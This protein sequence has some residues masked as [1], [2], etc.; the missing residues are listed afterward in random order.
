MYSAYKFRLYPN[1][2]QTRELE[3]M[4]ETHRRLYND[5][6]DWRKT[7]W[8]IFGVSVSGRSQERWYTKA[9]RRHPFYSR[10]NNN[11]A[12]LTIKRLDRAFVMFFRGAQDGVKWGY[13]RFKSKERFN[14]F[15]FRIDPRGQANGAKLVGG[16]LR[17]QHVG[18]IPVKLHRDV[19]G[20]PR[21]LTL[22]CEAGK[23][24]VV[25]QCDLGD[26]SVAPSSRPAVGIDLGIESFL[27]TSE[28][29]QEPNPRFFKSAMP[30]LRK[31]ARA[32]SRKLRGGKNRR[33]AAKRLARLH[34][35]VR[36]LRREHHHQIS[37]K[38]VRRHGLIAAERLN[39][40][41]MVRNSRRAG[42]I[43]DA[44]WFGFL[45]ILGHKAESAGVRV[46]LVEPR[47]TSQECSRCGKVV[48]KLLKVRWHD[49]PHCGLSLHRDHNAALN[50]LARARV[51]AR[52]WACGTERSGLPQACPEKECRKVDASG[53]GGPSSPFT[54][55]VALPGR[56]AQRK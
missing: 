41:G 19:Q 34:S 45:T 43:K 9:W 21:G 25:L 30:Q 1:V 10:L 33:K 54:Q 12:I 4:L 8:E 20:K 24:F 38:L 14:S 16:R 44:G 47:G 37:L 31:A 6:L 36:N 40:R 51:Q 35:R 55:S 23:W 22:T 26:V 50:I 11:S 5:C 18:A 17:V 53:H 7:A 56:P 13:P 52:I 39:I 2:N 3:T 29:D 27:T 49:C 42:A 48:P 28:G 46:E 15:S 32:V